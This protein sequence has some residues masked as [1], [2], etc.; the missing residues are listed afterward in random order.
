MAGLFLLRYRSMNM[1][2]RSSARGFSKG[3][4]VVKSGPSLAVARC[5]VTSTEFFGELGHL[6]WGAGTLWRGALIV[7]NGNCTQNSIFVVKIFRVF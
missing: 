1:M 6:G 7:A 2:R 3:T 5:C 4:E